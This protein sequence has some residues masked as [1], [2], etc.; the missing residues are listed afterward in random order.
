[1]RLTSFR[2]LLS[3]A[4]ANTW[5]VFAD[6]ATQAFLN[7]VRPADKPLYASYPE[8]YKRPGHCVLL[9][10]FLY[11]LHDSPLGFFSCVK[12]HLLNDQ[13]FKQSRTDECLFYKDG[14]YVI[15]HV[16]D[17]CSTGK[18]GPLADFR[19][20]ACRRKKSAW[21]ANPKYEG[22]CKDAKLQKRYRSL[23]GSIM[24]PAVTCRPDVQAAVSALSAHLWTTRSLELKFSSKM[25]GTTSFYGTI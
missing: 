6:D 25:S 13:Q 1:M 21:D 5:D 23:V 11:G 22:P 12:D 20:K 15:V 3:V 8:G 7:A 24:H 2:I 19:K 9:K 4:A 14:V 10:R 18:P 16:D 17:F